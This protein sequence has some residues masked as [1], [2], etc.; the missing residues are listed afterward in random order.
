MQVGTKEDRRKID[1]Q[2]DRNAGRHAVTPTS[3]VQKAC[4]SSSWQSARAVASS[5]RHLP[6]H[7]II[8]IANII[9]IH[10]YSHQINQIIITSHYYH[11][12]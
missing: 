8:V 6:D 10:H 11:P 3:L 2:K 7:S 1:R 9:K 4:C 5:T 12:A